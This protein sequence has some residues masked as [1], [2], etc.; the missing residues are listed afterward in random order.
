MIELFNSTLGAGTL[1]HAS[2]EIF[3]IVPKATNV[4]L[5]EVLIAGFI[6]FFGLFSLA[7]FLS[8]FSLSLFLS[9]FQGS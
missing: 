4:H 9:S 6:V 7:L 8:F 1:D 3:K 5:A 2:E